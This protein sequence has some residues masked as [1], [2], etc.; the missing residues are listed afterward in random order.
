MVEGESKK[1]QLERMS[2]AAVDKPAVAGKSLSAA[3]EVRRY[4]SSV[5]TALSVAGSQL[6]VEVL[7][8]LLSGRK[9]V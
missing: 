1:N 6:L 8:G 3:S 7:T 2:R 4:I 9:R 5:W